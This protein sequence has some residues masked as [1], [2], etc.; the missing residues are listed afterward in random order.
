MDSFVVKNGKL[1]EELSPPIVSS[2]PAC[3]T[4]SSSSS[5]S[6]SS[7]KSATSSSS[8]TDGC[9]SKLSARKPCVV[10]RVMG[11]LLR[12]KQMAKQASETEQK[13]REQAAAA[14][15]ETA[16][17]VLYNDEIHTFDEVLI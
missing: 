3:A 14:C 13:E 15:T 10:T 2:A 5:G 11:P 9:Q 8:L 17:L 12:K 7:C 4:A 16:A 6:S 1:P